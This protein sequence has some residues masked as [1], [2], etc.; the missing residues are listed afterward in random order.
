MHSQKSEL[1][2]GRRITTAQRRFTALL[3]H[4][5]TEPPGT[6]ARGDPANE[7]NKPRSLP[8]GLSDHPATIDG[9]C[10]YIIA[11]FTATKCGDVT[12]ASKFDPD[13]VV[14]TRSG[15]VAFEHAPEASS[16]HTH[17]R[18][19]FRIEVVAPAERPNRDAVPL[20]AVAQCGTLAP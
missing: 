18:I 5:G 3:R 9:N 11:N 17:D 1:E 16:F 6:R 4:R 20:N 14:P 19:S 15:V 7:S 2:R 8:Q 12:P 13:R 10:R